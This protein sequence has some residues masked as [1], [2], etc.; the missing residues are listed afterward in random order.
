MNVTEAQSLCLPVVWVAYSALL[1]SFLPSAVQDSVPGRSL[2]A[3]L[4]W[5]WSLKEWNSVRAAGVLLSVIGFNVERAFIKCGM[6]QFEESQPFISKWRKWETSQ[7]ETYIAS[8]QRIDPL[9]PIITEIRSIQECTG[10]DV[11]P[12]G[13][14]EYSQSTFS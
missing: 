10:C 4:V 13:S 14:D 5:R 6:R 1:Q 11:I 2:L 3:V 12:W 8:F 7:R 9:G